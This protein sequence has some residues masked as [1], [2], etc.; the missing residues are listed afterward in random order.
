MTGDSEV[1]AE[2]RGLLVSGVVKP[3]PLWILWPT[4]S[5]QLSKDER[6]KPKDGEH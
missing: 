2:V 5:A 4:S 1:E 3:C 6:K